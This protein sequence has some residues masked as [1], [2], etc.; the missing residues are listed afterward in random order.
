MAVQTLRGRPQDYIRS[1]TQYKAT[2]GMSRWH[3]LLDWVGGYPFEVARPEEIF[4]FYS[5]R[6]FQL[7]RLRTCGDGLGCNEFVMRRAG[8]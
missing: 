2:R 5:E 1:W 6:G 3:D 8:S 4:Q 7:E